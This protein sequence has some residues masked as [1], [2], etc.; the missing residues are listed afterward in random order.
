FAAGIVAFL[1]KTATFHTVSGGQLLPYRLPLSAFAFAAAGGVLGIVAVLVPAFIA[2]RRGIVEFLQA[3]AR[4]GRS[5]LQRYYLDLGLAALA[6]LALWEL[7]QRGS[8]FDPHSVGGWS[9]D[10]VLLLSPL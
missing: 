3:S 2:A 1:G 6:G 9:A 7:N 5:L 8:V 4:P 10:P